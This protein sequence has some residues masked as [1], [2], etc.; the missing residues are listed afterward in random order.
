MDEFF[1]QPLTKTALNKRYQKMPIIINSILLAWKR[2]HQKLFK[3]P[4]STEC[5]HQ[6][7]LLNEI[8]KYTQ[9]INKLWKLYKRYFLDEFNLYRLKKRSKNWPTTH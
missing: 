5:I 7:V 6:C 3:Y 1:K 9:S 8:E 4:M 2:Y